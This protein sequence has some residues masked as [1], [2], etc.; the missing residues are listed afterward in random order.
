VIYPALGEVE[1]H[2]ATSVAC[3]LL[4]IARASVYRWRAPRMHGP[5]REPA[6]VEAPAALTAGERAQLLAWL[7]SDRFADKAPEQ[8][9]AIGLDEGVYLGSV[10]TMYR[11][12][13]AQ[14]QVRERRAQ[15][16]HPP[17]KHPRLLAAGPHQI[18]SW[19]ITKLRGSCRRE[20]FDLYAIMDIF[21][22]KM[23]H[24][25]V[26]LTE[27]GELARDFI[28]H[29][30]E[31]NDGV[32]P[33]QI[34]S[35]NGTSMTSK[36]VADLLFDLQITRSLSRPKVSNDNPY[37]EAAFKTLK[38]CPAFP[39]NFTT[40]GEAAEFTDIFF[41]Y[42]NNEHRHSGIGL[43]TP[44]SVHD[45][46]WKY[47]RDRRQAVLDAAYRAH[48]ERFVKGP[49]Q[50]PKPPAQVWINNPRSKIETSDDSH[51]R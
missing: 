25:E 13:R 36:S 37:S 29:A 18:W 51:T 26:H 50:A 8:V 34:H 24:W 47:V 22:R 4:G 19:D 3:R 49:P 11:L 7:D 48:P 5:A 46:T 1:A 43:H 42:Y 21:S 30:V 23:I 28:D 41:A 33:Q 35:D 15:A 2:A 38:Y 12:L 6:P 32:M 16:R 39:G 20:F 40:R 14:G 27:T 44:Q 45:G 17:R 10:S 31:A 9:W